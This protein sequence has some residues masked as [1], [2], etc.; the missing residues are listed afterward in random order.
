M[1]KL[2]S[3]Y[4]SA[5]I[6]FD[7]WKKLTKSWIRTISPNTTDN[8][9]VAAVVMSFSHSSTREGVLDLILDLDENHLYPEN[10]PPLQVAA[11][12]TEDENGVKTERDLTSSR[13]RKIS[14]LDFIFTTL[15]SKFG[16]NEDEKIFMYYE[17]FEML[18]RDHNTSMKEYIIQF[19]SAHRKL[20]GSG[21]VLNDAILAYRL[22]KGASLGKD[23]KLVRTSVTKMTCDE[24]KKTLLKMAD[25]VVCTSDRK[26]KVL[27]SIQRVQVKDEPIDVLY[28]KESRYSST[29]EDDNWSGDNCSMANE[30]ENEVFYSNRQPPNWRNR[31]KRDHEGHSFDH[32]N[33]RKKVQFSGS[34]KRPLNQES[35]SKPRADRQK[36]RTNQLSEC[37]ICKSIMHWAADCPHRTDENRK[38]NKPEQILKVDSVLMDEEYLTYVTHGG[39]NLALIDSGATKTVCGRNWFETFVASLDSKDQKMIKEEDSS[40]LFRFGDGN[41]VK[42]EIVKV[43]PTVICGQEVRIKANIVDN[44][45]P[46]LIS[47]NTLAKAKANLNF[48]HGV[49]EMDG[50]QQTLINTPSG[51]YAVPIG[52]NVDNLTYVATEHTVY[53]AEGSD[54]PQ[55]I[56]QKIHRYFAHASVDRLKK[57]VNSTSHELKNEIC[58]A[59]DKLDCDLCK[60]HRREAP[61]PKTC[62]PLADRFNQTVALDLKF[63]D[64]EEIVLH[65]IDILTRFSAATII[66]NKSQKTIVA[67]FFK[68]WIAPFGRPEQT[69]CDNG[70]EFCNTDFVDMCRNM[71]INMKTTAAFAPFSNGIVERH[72]G[73]LAEM[74]YKIRD[75]IKCNTSIALSWAV[76]AKNNISN[77]FG[78]SPQQLVLGYNSPVPGLDDAKVKLSQL[79]GISA[80]QL[81]ADNIN[82]MHHAR[83]AFLEAQ[84]SDRLKRALKDKVYQAYEK[85]YY[86]G[87]EVYYRTDSKTWK[88]PGVVIGQYQ[89][90]VLVKTGGLFV[91]VHPSKIIL[92]TAADATIN[93][94]T[95][96][97]KNTEKAVGIPDEQESSS[98]SEEEQQLTISQRETSVFNHG[99]VDH[100]ENEEEQQQMS[101]PSEI[102]EPTTVEAVEPT[103]DSIQLETTVN[104]NVNWENIVRDDKKGR[105]V[106]KSGD[107]IRYKTVPGSDFQQA[108]VL[109]NAGRIT[110][111][112]KDRY[113]VESAEGNKF[114]IFA[115]KMDS[116]E[117]RLYDTALCVENDESVMYTQV[118]DKKML[119]KIEVAKKAEV[120]NF[121]QFEVFKEVP[122]NSCPD[123]DH[124][125]TSRWVI[126]QKGDGRI[127]ARIVARGY[128]ESEKF[129]ETDAPT[130]DKTNI[131]TFL[132]VIAMKGWEAGS[133]DVKAAFLQSH[134]LKREVF[135]LPPKDIRKPQTIW[136]I[137][138]PVYGLKDSAMNWYK[139]LDHDLQ[140]LG[141][142]K[143]TLD[144]TVY[145]YYNNGSELL[146]LFVC[147]VDDFLYSIGNSIF[148][149]QVI[150][151]IE[152]KYSISSQN[153]GSFTYVGLNIKPFK[154]GLS[155]DQEDYALKIK[156]ADLSKITGEENSLLDNEGKKIYQGLLGKLNWLAHQS[157]PELSFYAYN[158]SLFSQAPTVGNI[159]KLNSIVRKIPSGPSKL[160]LAKLDM[161]SLQFVCFS[162]ASYANILP[163]KINSGEGYL[164]F[165]C[166]KYGNC[167]LLNWKSKK[168]NRVVHSTL[169]AEC[170]GLVDSIGDAVYTRNVLEEILFNNARSYQIPIHMYVDSKQLFS[171]VSSNHMVTEK[172]LR[173]NIAELKEMVSGDLNISPYWIPTKLMLSDCL[174]KLGASTRELQQVMENGFIDLEELK[175]NRA[176]LRSE[177]V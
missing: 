118:P 20:T 171:A 146:G 30:S 63:L 144:P 116:L 85:R 150:M 5:T 137:K 136:K 161:E 159:R 170:L 89:K 50:C 69:L 149:E 167:A 102:V 114:S 53:T 132:T 52:P 172:L 62:L 134:E 3:P 156:P 16:I 165:L 22:L 14:G 87:D 139:T 98:D 112:N 145:R 101:C 115:D 74:V 127:K 72:N 24:M 65:C 31:P 48:E 142:T 126:N 117:K 130:V 166:D 32:Y 152:L 76:S 164:T 125:V 103:G 47:K 141:C 147:H 113:N 158:Y 27:P 155:I 43:I 94:D 140:A 41:A 163:E 157:R 104:G 13:E 10:M 1:V 151:K 25:G 55:K 68:I 84:N 67:N 78:F 28:Q 173:I 49:L 129:L 95:V 169:G 96:Q 71:M 128:E 29:D 4:F 36:S 75:D 42:S 162:D 34:G 26:A 11:Q 92:K 100:S 7:K 60:K 21:V 8:E 105:F 124:L 154:G 81:V 77:V 59:L 38:F 15:E 135:L 82:A 133:L 61:K 40:C 106:L 6:E 83:T 57:F 111:V 93:C 177:I 131:R 174:T 109:G 122:I 86:P 66:P 120:E 70:K 64:T 19:E 58:Q 176:C 90:L 79:D 23:E 168:I 39:E 9:I 18:K 2:K 143:S 138:K 37:H 51:H 119:E 107:E 12:P 160:V 35:Y 56:A 108:T 33:R 45:I 44:D 99:R 110:G 123:K 148:S 97:A 88:G 46:L 91:R 54:K 153:L 17:N 80:S 121:K 73:L 175:C